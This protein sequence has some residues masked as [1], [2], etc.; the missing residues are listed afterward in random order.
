MEAKFGAMGSLTLGIGGG[1]HSKE[2]KWPLETG[3]A[4]KPLLPRN[5][6]KELALRTSS[7]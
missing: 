5:L 6:Q 1:A 2:C 7:F 4:R 3:K